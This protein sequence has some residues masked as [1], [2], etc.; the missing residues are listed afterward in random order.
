[1]NE[2]FTEKDR[3]WMIY[4]TAQECFYGQ[5]ITEPMLTFNDLMDIMMFVITGDGKYIGF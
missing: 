1:M 2:Q 4:S 3:A 5:Q